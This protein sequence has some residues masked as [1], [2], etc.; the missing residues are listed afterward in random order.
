MTWIARVRIVKV[1]TEERSE[2]AQLA[3]RFLL[4]SVIAFV[5]RYER[6]GRREMRQATI[7][8]PGRPENS[9][10]RDCG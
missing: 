2:N 3:H 8:A 10:A 5:R 4:S 7:F 1:A 6:L 9:V